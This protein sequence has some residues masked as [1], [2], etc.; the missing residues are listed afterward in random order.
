M[1]SGPEPP[2]T[3][4]EKILL[5]QLN[6]LMPGKCILIRG[7]LN[8]IDLSE[9]ANKYKDQLEI[10]DS[11]VGSELNEIMCASRFIICRSGYSTLLD[12]AII[13]KPALLIPTPGQPEQ[14]YLSDELERKKLFHS[15]AQGEINLK[16]DIEIA[17]AMNGYE[18]INEEQTLD[19]RLDL[20]IGQM[21]VKSDSDSHRE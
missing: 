8:G 11:V 12:L 17:K 9:Y 10:K 20:L 18:K 13:Q 14:E 1:L 21:E 15:V 19:E 6:A 5:E 3:I 2:R 4:L 16:K 7:L